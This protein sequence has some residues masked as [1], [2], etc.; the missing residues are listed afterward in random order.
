MTII[1]VKLKSSNEILTTWVDKRVGLKVGTII[2]LKNWP[3]SDKRWEIIELWNNEH[4]ST[5]FD[6][7]RKWD[8]NI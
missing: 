2:T 7:H 1:Q 3:E 6:W 5:D 8:N 4:E